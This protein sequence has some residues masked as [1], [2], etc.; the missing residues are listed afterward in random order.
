[1]I[2]TKLKST[3]MD[4][5]QLVPMVQNNTQD[6][7]GAVPKKWSGEAGVLLGGEPGTCQRLQ[8][9]RRHGVLHLHPRMNHGS[10]SSSPQGELH[11]NSF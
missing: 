1:M 4:V 6:A 11:V 9:P 2:A 10:K 3:P 8:S 7:L 5:Q